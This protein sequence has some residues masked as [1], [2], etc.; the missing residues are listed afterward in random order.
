MN[1]KVFDAEVSCVLTASSSFESF[2][3]ESFQ[4]ENN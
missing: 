2:A 4:E 1:S 3:T